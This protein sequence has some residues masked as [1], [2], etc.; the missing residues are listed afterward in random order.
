MLSCHGS[1]GPSRSTLNPLC[2]RW[3]I[4]NNIMRATCCHSLNKSVHLTTGALCISQN[5]SR[6]VDL[7]YWTW[8]MRRRRGLNWWGGCYFRSECIWVAFKYFCNG[9]FANLFVLYIVTAAIAVAVSAIFTTGEAL[10]VEFKAPW[11]FTIAIFLVLIR[12]RL[13]RRATDWRGN[14]V[15]Y[16]RIIEAG[17]SW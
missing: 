6:R 1:L 5:H 11:I 17:R 15:L 8:M 10:T 14:L 7:R 2:M 13:T 3:K 12:L 9:L 4:R 16:V